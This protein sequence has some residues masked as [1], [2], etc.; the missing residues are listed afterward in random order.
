V[1]AALPDTEKALVAYLAAHPVLAPLHGGR[2]GTELRT[3]D[4]CLQVTSLGGPQPWPW[5]STPEFQISTW[6]GTKGEA[7]ALD[8]A[9]AAA[10][11]DLVGVSI[12]GGTIIG[13]AVRL[14]HLWRPDE[15]TGRA[16]YRTDIALTAMP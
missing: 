16:R 3:A 5:E 15:T 6:G 10:A 13:A 1:Y 7:S 8:L 4:I 12:P 11:F 9:V 2:V 14:A